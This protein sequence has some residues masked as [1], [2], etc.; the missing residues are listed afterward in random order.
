M[1]VRT[2]LT[3]VLAISLVGA[4]SAV[5][6]T[7]PRPKPLCTLLKDDS[8][9]GTWVVPVV[10]SPALDIISGDISTG[11]KTMVAVLR[12][13]STDFA[14]TSDKWSSTGYSWSFGVTSS[15][16]QK[17]QFEAARHVTGTMDEDV[18]VDGKSVPFQFKIVGKTF[19]WTIQRKVSPNLS[20]PKNVFREFRG[21]SEV[22]SST[23][24]GAFTGASVY[25]D[26]ASSCV[27]A[28]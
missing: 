1:R 14:P 16:G 15:L 26:R 19:V 21:G 13:G 24:D 2:I 27:H 18:T 4:T 20:R 12:L 23:A 22:E 17:Y 3:C 6:A 25:P 11:P 5:A 10:E 8:G 9:D 7:K 28:D